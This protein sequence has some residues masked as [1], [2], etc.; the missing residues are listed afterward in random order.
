MFKPVDDSESKEHESPMS[1]ARVD[2][3]EKVWRCSGGTCVH[4]ARC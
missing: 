3:N 4:I 1:M 2:L